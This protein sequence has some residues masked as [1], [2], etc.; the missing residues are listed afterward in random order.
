[1]RGIW[2]LPFIILTMTTPAVIATKT[3]A[4]ATDKAD[5]YLK[6]SDKTRGQSHIKLHF[7]LYF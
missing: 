5:V 4:K 1:M 6:E 7:A 3:T 2:M